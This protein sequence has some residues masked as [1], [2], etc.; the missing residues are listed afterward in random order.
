M[1]SPTMLCGIKLMYRGPRFTR[2]SRSITATIV[3]DSFHVAPVIADTVSEDHAS[4]SIHSRYG[5]GN[6]TVTLRY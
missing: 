1:A 3:S 6:L 5:I 4:I 2:I